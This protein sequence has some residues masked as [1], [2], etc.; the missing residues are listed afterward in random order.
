MTIELRRTLTLAT[1]VLALCLLITALGSADQPDAEAKPADESAPAAQ[2]APVP[3]TGAAPAGMLAFRDPVTGELRSP[4]PAEIDAMRPELE[5]IYNQ[6]SEG[7]EEIVLPDGSVGIDLQGRFMSSVVAIVGPDG[8][9]RTRCVHSAEGLLEPVAPADKA[10]PT[11]Q[12]AVRQ[13]TA[14]K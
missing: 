5:A 1:G 7:L 9:V 11:A 14:V 4:T 13:T 8:T 6:S 10:A 12:T 3:A 2:A